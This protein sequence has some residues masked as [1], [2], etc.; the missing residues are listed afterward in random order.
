MCA[1]PTP[2]EHGVAT[3]IFS[4]TQNGESITSGPIVQPDSRHLYDRV[5]RSYCSEMRDRACAGLLFA[6]IPR[7]PCL[8]NKVVGNE[9]DRWPNTLI[10]NRTDVS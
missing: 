2:L 8:A 6:E 4:R 5:H 10:E 9:L 3:S 7:N 1:P